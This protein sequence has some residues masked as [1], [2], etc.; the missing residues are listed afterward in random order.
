M[1]KDTSAW[2]NKKE[3]LETEQA[4]LRGVEASLV[5]LDEQG[6]AARIASA[7]AARDEAQADFAR[8]AAQALLSELCLHAADPVEAVQRARTSVWLARATAAVEAAQREVA[9]AEAGDGRDESNRTLQERLA[10]VQNAQV[11]VEHG[12]ATA[13]TLSSIIEEPCSRECS[14]EVARAGLQRVGLTGSCAQTTA[15]GKARA[16]EVA[17]KHLAKQ[18]AETRKTLA[19]KQSDA[20][21][22]QQAC[23]CPEASCRHGCIVAF[24]ADF[25][26][27]QSHCTVKSVCHT[28]DAEGTIAKLHRCSVRHYRIWR[29]RRRH[30]QT[31]SGG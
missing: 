18:L 20:G 2:S 19:A 5:E 23:P 13:A 16:A 4:A 3:A 1:V 12:F 27:S 10:D 6:I 14:C 21:K 9:G 29:R 24:P 31:A 8:H 15:E 28:T 11:Q 17:A 30:W 22:L 26:H 25:A 7:A